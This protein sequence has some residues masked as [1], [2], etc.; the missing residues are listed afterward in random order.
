MV[1]PRLRGP[2]GEDHSRKWHSN[3]SFLSHAALVRP[4]ASVMEDLAVKSVLRLVSGNGL[5]RSLRIFR[6]LSAIF[7]GALVVGA[8]GCENDEAAREFRQAAAPALESGLNTIL[9]G[10]VSSGFDIADSEANASADDNAATP[11]T[12]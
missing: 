5:P 4:F 2:K 9:T 12:P 1:P 8:I 3:C 7:A 10:L 11:A 6:P